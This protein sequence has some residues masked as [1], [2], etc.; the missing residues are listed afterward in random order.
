LERLNKELIFVT[1]SRIASIYEQ[2]IYADL[3][4]VFHQNGYNITIISPVERNLK[5]NTNLREAD[6]ICYLEVKTFNIQKSNFLEKGLGTLLISYQYIQAIKNHLKNKKFDLILYTTPPITF[7]PVIKFLKNK[8]N[9]FCYLLLKDIFPQNAVDLKIISKKSLLYNFF[10]KQEIK[11][12]NISDYIGCMSKRNYDYLLE[13]NKYINKNKV[14]INPNSINIKERVVVKNLSNT[15]K[16]TIIYGGNLGKPQGIK[17]LINAIKSCNSIINI[18]FLI[19]GNGTDDYLIKDWIINEAPENIQYF[20]MLPKNEY[21]KLLEN[22]TIG[23]ICLDKNFTIPNYPSRLLSY[24]EY[25]IP[26]I[27]LTDKNT[28]IGIDA[29]E[30]GYGFWCLTDDTDSFKNFIL[31]FKNNPEIITKM[32][33]NAFN[34]LKNN[35]DVINSFNI[36]DKHINH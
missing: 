11:L 17:Y 33:E 31:K 28:D 2:S 19:V 8:Y 27:C 22:A 23:I 13:N 25:K 9:S 32:G 1:L 14:E 12:Y 3:L 26:V 24:M 21:D 10:R 29:N 4:K 6:K 18:E 16:L 36:I 35:F 20:E 34:Y 15:N 30:N 7:F 5:I